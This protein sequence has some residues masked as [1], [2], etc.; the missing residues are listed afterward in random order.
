MTK[1]RWPDKMNMGMRTWTLSLTGV[2]RCVLNVDW[3]KTTGSLRLD[4]DLDVELDLS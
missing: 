2:K 4:F 3:S 1:N